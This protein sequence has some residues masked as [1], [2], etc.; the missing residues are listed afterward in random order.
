MSSALR[1][2]YKPRLDATL[3]GETAAFA[4]VYR[5]LLDRHY[6]DKKSGVLNTAADTQRRSNEICAKTSTP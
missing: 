5:F 1:F 2:V 6:A 4:A 3:E